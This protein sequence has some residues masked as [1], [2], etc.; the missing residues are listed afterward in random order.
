MSGLPGGIELGQ[1]TLNHPGDL[2]REAA[3]T[4]AGAIERG[5]KEE[6]LGNSA[7]DVRAD[8]VA[9]GVSVAEAQDN[10]LDAVG[11]AGSLTGELTTL[12][13]QNAQLL[14]V[15]RSNEGRAPKVRS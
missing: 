13:P 8:R 12:R 3:R 6:G 7:A 14:E 15:G 1:E 10:V 11:A 2:G 4:D 9:C 5:A